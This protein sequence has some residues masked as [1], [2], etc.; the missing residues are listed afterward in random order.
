MEKLYLIN[1]SNNNKITV[2]INNILFNLIFIPINPNNNK[3]ITAFLNEKQKNDLQKML[4]SCFEAEIK[5]N[6]PDYLEKDVQIEFSN[7]RYGG[8]IVFNNQLQVVGFMIF[9]QDYN[10]LIIIENICFDESLRD[11]KSVV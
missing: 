5:I 7:H 9:N 8:L 4:Y 11:R 3:S 10:N 6:N 2:E 1:Y